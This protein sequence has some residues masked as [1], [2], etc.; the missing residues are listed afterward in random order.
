MNGRT[1]TSG[2][3]VNNGISIPLEAPTNLMLSAGDQ[4]ISM[5]WTDPIDKYTETF[6]ELVSQ[7]SYDTIVRKEGSVP[8]SPH[9]GTVVAKITSKNQ[10]QNIPFTDTGMEN[11]KRWYYSVYSWNQFGTKSEPASGSGI[12]TGTIINQYKTTLSSRVGDIPMGGEYNRA[13]VFGSTRNHLIV[14]DPDVNWFAY[15]SNLVK[16]NIANHGNNYTDET[17]SASSTTI[18]HYATFFRNANDDIFPWKSIDDNLVV[19]EHPFETRRMDQFCLANV[20]NEIGIIARNKSGFMFNENLVLQSITTT[21]ANVPLSSSSYAGFDGEYFYDVDGVAHSASPDLDSVASSTN[22]EH[23]K[24][25]YGEQ[26][27]AAIDDRTLV[28]QSIDGIW[29]ISDNYEENERSNLNVGMDCQTIGCGLIFKF[30]NGMG[31]VFYGGT[32]IID[33]NLVLSDGS[34][35][36]PFKGLSSLGHDERFD[37]GSSDLRAHRFANYVA[38]PLTMKKWDDIYRVYEKRMSVYIIENGYESDLKEV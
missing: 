12:P 38:I 14:I 9:D 36:F 10:H 17:S 1:N 15:N 31:A 4:K 11:D 8:S 26:K 34:S 6:N 30:S 16:S 20:N 18:G 22:D 28:A 21:R 7:W 35:V 13:F 32:D 29:N 19:S 37:S 27:A 3:T 23:Y 25:F 24:I 5:T 33:K 2:I